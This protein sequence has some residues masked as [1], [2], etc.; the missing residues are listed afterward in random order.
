MERKY[1]VSLSIIFLLLITWFFIKQ[2]NN[3]KEIEVI[4]QKIDQDTIYN[5]NI[6]ENVRYESKDIRK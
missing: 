4:K 1:K 3:K 5:S 2:T 6:I